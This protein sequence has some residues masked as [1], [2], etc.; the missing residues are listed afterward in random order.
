MLLNIKQFLDGLYSYRYQLIQEGEFENDARSEGNLS[1]KEVV[2][3]EEA[4]YIVQEKDI[5]SKIRVVDEVKRKFS[6]QC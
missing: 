6:G 1:D 2:K 4:P 5:L 3:S